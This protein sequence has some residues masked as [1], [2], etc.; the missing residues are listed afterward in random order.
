MVEPGEAVAGREP[1]QRDGDRQRAVEEQQ[2]LHRS[3]PAQTLSPLSPG[4]PFGVCTPEMRGVRL[5]LAGCLVPLPSAE[6]CIGP[7]PGPAG[8]RCEAAAQTAPLTCIK[9]AA[10]MRMAAA[11]NDQLVLVQE[12]LSVVGLTVVNKQP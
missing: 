7:G 4:C 9:H 10:P 6:V 1:A 12:G 11:V 3:G 2:P 8:P 5:P